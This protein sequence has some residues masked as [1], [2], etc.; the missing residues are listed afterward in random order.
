MILL[1][2]KDD[3][4]GMERVSSWKRNDDPLRKGMTILSEKIDDPPSK[5]MILSQWKDV[6][7]GKERRSSR[8]GK[9]IIS[10]KIS[11]RKR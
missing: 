6:L 10:E 11:E 1:D 9:M 2:R 7:L 3:P 5:K 4:V 8:K